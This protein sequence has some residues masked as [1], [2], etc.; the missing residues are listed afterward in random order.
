MLSP[1]PLQQAEFAP[2][3]T[4]PGLTAIFLLLPPHASKATQRTKANGPMSKAKFNPY[5]AV[6]T[7]K[8][9][10]APL[11]MTNVCLL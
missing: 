9:V 5:G 6:N 3:Q 4:Y 8:P 10:L 1:L 11:Q 2:W 7:L